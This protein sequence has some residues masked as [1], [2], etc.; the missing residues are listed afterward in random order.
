M[1]DCSIKKKKKKDGDFPGGPVVK[2]PP[3][4]AGDSGLILGRGT[5]I[6]HTVK[7][8]HL[9]ATTTEA[10]ELWSLCAATRESVPCNKKKDP[11]CHN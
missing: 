5:K 6:P 3:C 1:N 4:N 2:N 9:R 10:Q 8:L 7:Q 11:V